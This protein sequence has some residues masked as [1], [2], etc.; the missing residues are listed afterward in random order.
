M[1]FRHGVLIV[2]LAGALSIGWADTQA[3][4]RQIRFNNAQLTAQLAR[5][6]PLARCLFGKLG[7]VVLKSPRVQMKADDD[8]LFLTA[9]VEVRPASTHPASGQGTVQIAGKPRYDGR[10]G[11]FFIDEPELL[12]LSMPGVR[13]SDARMASGLVN[14]MLADEL[15]SKQPVWTLDETDPQQAMIRLSLRRVEVRAGMLVVTLGDDEVPD[16]DSFLDEPAPAQGS[17][18]PAAGK[19]PGNGTH[20]GGPRGGEEGEHS[21]SPALR[22]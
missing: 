11:A 9:R 19:K 18:E 13:A 12:D 5:S 7:C 14:A 1:R 4:Q 10:V 21:A 20:P 6:F 22:T 17:D 8:R 15:F 2:L 3:Q 16:D